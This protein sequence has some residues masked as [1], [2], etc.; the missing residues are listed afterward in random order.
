M[1]N[2]IADSAKN[3]WDL[4]DLKE[5]AREQHVYESYV[6]LMRDKSDFFSKLT[7]DQLKVVIDEAMEKLQLAPERRKMLLDKVK[8]YQ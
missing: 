1:L 3:L 6:N 8:K 7:N 2:I 4:F 5:N